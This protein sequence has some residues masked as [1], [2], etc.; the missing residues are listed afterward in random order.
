MNKLFHKF[1]A[2]SKEFGGFSYAI[3]QYSRIQVRFIEIFYFKRLAIYFDI[4]RVH[5]EVNRVFCKGFVRLN[6]RGSDFSSI[7]PL[8]L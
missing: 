4:S 8:L 2:F 5:N 6:S 7:H 1:Y 3:K